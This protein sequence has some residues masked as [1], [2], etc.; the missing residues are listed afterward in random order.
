MSCLDHIQKHVPIDVYAKGG[1]LFIRNTKTHT[2]S[3]LEWKGRIRD[4][5][6]YMNIRVDKSIGK[7]TFTLFPYSIK[8]YTLDRNARTYIHQNENALAEKKRT[9]TRI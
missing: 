5:Y 8:L 1:S 2:R 6:P 7:Y 3:Q 9:H 4:K